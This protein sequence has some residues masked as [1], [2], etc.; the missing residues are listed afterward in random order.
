[1]AGSRT[2]ATEVLGRGHPWLSLA[3]ALCVIAVL[4]GGGLVLGL[5]GSFAE[6]GGG[7]S[8]D[9]WA[10][11]L[12]E[13]RVWRS[14]GLSLW[15]AGASTALSCGIG[16]GA[17]L[18]LRRSFPG[19]GLARL[20]FQINLTI[21]HAV[22]ALGILWLLSQSGFLARLVAGAGGIDTPAD[23]PPLTQDRFAIGIIAHY[24]WKEVP[25]VGLILLANMQ[26]LGDDP[27]SAA[28]TLGAGPFAAMRLVLL[29]L[30]MPALVRAG[31]IVFAFAFGAW[32][33]PVLLGQSSPAALPVLAWQRF[34]SPDLAARPEAMALAMLIALVS[35]LLIRAAFTARR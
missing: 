5:A 34:T 29:P 4:F 27:E 6:R 25:F 13:G 8:L 7:W 24:V 22:G 3:P 15:I 33:V 20:L 11:V 30:L 1:M 26:S 19:Q 2:S 12:S 23:F 28:R 21:P 17:A 35:A 10:Q 32:E 9:A 16:L 14:L 31:A 18:L